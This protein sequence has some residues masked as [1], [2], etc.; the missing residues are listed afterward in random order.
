MLIYLFFIVWMEHDDCLKELLM[1]TRRIGFM[2]IAKLAA[3][4]C[5]ALLAG[6]G[7][8]P[9]MMPDMAMQP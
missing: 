6:C 4:L 9:T 8:I 2:S 7:S 1:N 5:L 3:A